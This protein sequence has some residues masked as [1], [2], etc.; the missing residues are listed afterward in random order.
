MRQQNK[1]CHIH[2][3]Q[4]KYKITW[5]GSGA[6]LMV[7]NAFHPLDSGEFTCI[8]SNAA[9]EDKKTLILD[10]H[11]E[12]INVFYVTDTLLV[13]NVSVRSVVAILKIWIHGFPPFP[14]FLTKIL[15]GRNLVTSLGE[16]CTSA[17]SSNSSY[18]FQKLILEL[19]LGSTDKTGMCIAS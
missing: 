14:T 16:L 13:R 17:R 8:A 9:G 3:D 18:F 2:G 15:L 7:Q 5:T 6:E 12:L 19:L 10:V 4:P 11:G 1:T